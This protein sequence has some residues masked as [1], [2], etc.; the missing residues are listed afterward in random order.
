MQ[1]PS[2]DKRSDLDNID[3]LYILEPHGWSTCILCIGD[4]IHTI[5]SISHAF[6]DPME[7]L[8]SAT[9]SLLK[10]TSEIEFIWWHEPGGTQW[11]IVRNNDERHKAIVT[12]EELSSSYGDSIIQGKI[13]AEFEI[14]I[15]HFSTLI[16]Y[17]MKKIETLLKEKSFEKNR[18]GEF[19]YAEF[20]KLEAF[21]E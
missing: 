6:A 13:L 15:N 1:L 14:K 16:Y 9:I 18:S 3:I 4:K 7:D 12:V 8:V 10:G 5:D 11:K 19:P 21:F 17:Q 2:N 20:R